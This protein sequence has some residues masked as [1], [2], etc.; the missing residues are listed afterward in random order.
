MTPTWDR[1]WTNANL[2]TLRGEEGWGVVERGAIAVSGDRIGWV[3]PMDAFEDAA[4]ETIDLGGLWVTPGLIDCHTHL[5]YAGDRSREFEM[6]LGGAKYEDIARAGG[7]ILSTVKAT[8]AA[9]EAQL[10]ELAARRLECLADDGATT[11][12]VKSGYGLDLENELKQLRAARAAG[13]LANVRVTTTLL[14]AHALPPEYAGDRAGYLNLVCDE[15]IPTAAAEGLAD[16]VDAFCETI[17]FTPAETARVFE[18]AT[19][20][21]LRVKLHADQLAD[22]GGASLAA[23]HGALSAD[24]LEY[25]GEAGLKAMAAA[26]TVAVLLPG[27]FYMLRETRKPP[28]EAMQRLGVTMALAS[29]HNPGTSPLLSL[30]LTMNLACVLF[31]LTPAEALRGLTVNGAR[32]LG[33]GEDR[34]RLAVG[35]RADLAIWDI[36]G[37]AELCYRV[38]ERLCVGR[39]LDGEPVS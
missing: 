37:P 21:G 35:Q 16:A 27:A 17:A 15:M 30:T 6:K 20:H 19:R 13:A 32:A 12:E 23:A 24:H 14:G 4:E 5:V 38:G 34:G 1:L 29:D 31:G 28:V 22:T 26:G 8:R 9:S 36:G 2:V 39:V 33:V 10:T 25:T 18:A 7:G 3:G 11:V